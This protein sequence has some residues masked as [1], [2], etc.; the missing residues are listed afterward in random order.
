M[1]NGGIWNAKILTMQGLSTI[2]TGLMAFSIGT[3]EEPLAKLDKSVSAAEASVQAAFLY[4]RLRRND[5][6]RL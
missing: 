3:L 1:W 4:S 5:N 6:E 2:S